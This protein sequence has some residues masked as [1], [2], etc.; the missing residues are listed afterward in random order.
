MIVGVAPPICG[1]DSNELCSNEL[2]CRRSGRPAASPDRLASFSQSLMFDGRLR[3]DLRSGRSDHR[4]N[5][6][7]ADGG[8]DGRA[9]EVSRSVRQTGMAG[10]SS[11]F[12]NGFHHS[13]GARQ[14][15]SLPRFACLR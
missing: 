14:T 4:R 10:E 13:G 6:N 8:G 7:E 11:R 1:N 15:R 2:A 3:T 9:G 12:A 5:G